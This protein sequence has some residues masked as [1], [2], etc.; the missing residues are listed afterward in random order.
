MLLGGAAIAWETGAVL[1]PGA[2]TEVGTDTGTVPGGGGRADGL[3]ARP[4]EKLPGTT[5]T[6]RLKVQN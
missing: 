1:I 5:K 4:G 2:L 3:P 6:Y